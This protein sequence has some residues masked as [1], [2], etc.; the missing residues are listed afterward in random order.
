[1][2]LIGKMN[3]ILFAL[4]LVLFTGCSTTQQATTEKVTEQAPPE[5]EIFV[6][7]SPGWV[8]LRDSSVNKLYFYAK[9]RGYPHASLAYYDKSSQAKPHSF[10]RRLLDDLDGHIAETDQQAFLDEVVDRV[11]IIQTE[12][13]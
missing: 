12:G 6:P 2:L 10:M 3:R 5:R 1:M 7:D 4:C 8:Y 9:E 13:Q 11:R